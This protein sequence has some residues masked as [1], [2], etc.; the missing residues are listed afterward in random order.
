MAHNK[1]AAMRRE[2][3]EQKKT[4][5]NSLEHEWLARATVHPVGG[6]AL[7]KMA[8]KYYKFGL[9]NG[10]STSSCIIFLALHEYFG[11]GEK[12]INTLMKCVAKESMKMDEAPT[13]FNVDFY[14]KKLEEVMDISL[15]SYSEDK[16][17]NT[18]Y[19]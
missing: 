13:E 3:R 17:L 10:M 1:R 12:R 2:A 9:S 5:L 8:M 18:D 7:D 19:K 11:F 16:I 6:K 4:K 14:Q 15:E